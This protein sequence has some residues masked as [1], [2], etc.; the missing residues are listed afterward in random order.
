MKKFFATALIAASF[1]PLTAQAEPPS[2]PLVCRG[3]PSMR[4]MT[5]HDVPDGVNTGNTHMT[6]FFRAGQ[7]ANNPAPGECVW[8]DRGFRPGEPENFVVSGN[9]E[10]AFQV[11]GD[12]RLVRDGSGLRLSAEGT[13]AAANDWNYIINTLMTG[14]MPTVHVYSQGGSMIVTR[15]GP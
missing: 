13:G 3:G 4:I 11:M 7:N 5:N 6:V 2:Y 14:N 9:V 8:V 15:V 12:G 1:L 10:F